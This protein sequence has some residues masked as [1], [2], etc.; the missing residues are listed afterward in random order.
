MTETTETPLRLASDARRAL[1]QG[2]TALARRRRERLADLVAYARAHSPF[3]RDLYRGLPERVEDPAQLPVT[4]KKTLMAHFDDWVTDREVTL[5][6]VQEFV[7]DP[8]L[9]GHRFQGRY[10]VSTTSGTSGVRG[11]F[12]T[13]ERN[14]AVHTALGART[15]GGLGLADGLR[16]LARAGRT[17]VVTA[18]GGHFFTVASTARFRLDHPWTGRIMRVFSIEQPLADLVDELN[19]YRP[20]TLSGFLSM[21]TL[22]AGEQQAGRLRIRPAVIIAGGETMTDEARDKLA[23]AFGAPVRAAYACTECGFLSTGCEHGWYHVNSDWAAVEPVDA[24]YRPVAPGEPSHTVLISNLA[25]RIQPILRYDLGDSVLVRPDPC[26][27]GNRLPALRVQGRAADVL[28][29][30]TGSGGDVGLSPMVVGARLDRV[31]GVEQFQVVQA[32][33][34]VVRVRLAAAEGADAERVWE[35]VRDALGGLLAEQGAGGVRVERAAEPPQKS[36]GGKFR[37]VVPLG[38]R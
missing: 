33:P 9:V 11:L 21:L 2:P 5:A 3:Y 37:R 4:D 38:P 7:A 13:D 12:L 31:P 18:P 24:E 29:F 10:L 16:V 27:C 6:K 15:S 35:E 25:N 23:A 14:L 36:S 17:A 34:A 26:P 28:T 30:P 1:R 19:R 22:L 8:A 20:A 32:E